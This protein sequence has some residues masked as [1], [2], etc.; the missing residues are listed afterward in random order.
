ENL[1]FSNINMEAKEGFSIHTAENVELHNVEVSTEIGPSFRIEDSKGILLENIK[2]RKP[3]SESPILEI[4]NSS[5]IFIYNNF[6]LAPTSVFLHA[7]G[8]KTEKVFM[9]NNHFENVQTPVTKGKLLKR[10]AVQEQ[11]SDK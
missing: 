7:T 6:P 10:G 2:S 8:D 4:H 5:N 3:S 1:T 11:K 9:I